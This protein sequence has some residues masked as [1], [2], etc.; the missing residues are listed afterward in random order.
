MKLQLNQSGKNSAQ[1]AD[2][3]GGRSA[4]G[5]AVTAALALSAFACS[6]E[7]TPPS[8]STGGT[9]GQPPAGGAGTGVVAGASPMPTGGNPSTSGGS[10][11]APGTSG[12]AATGGGG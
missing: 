4:C 11:G 10:A 9:G 1:L 5:F 8:P 6:S 2:R 12:S 3:L 7:T